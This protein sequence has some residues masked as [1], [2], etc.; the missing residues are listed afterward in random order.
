MSKLFDIPE[1]YNGQALF[2]SLE[3]LIAYA[4]EHEEELADIRIFS[5]RFDTDE[6]SE[7]VGGGK[8]CYTLSDMIHDFE[9]KNDSYFDDVK[10]Q[11]GSASICYEKY[12]EIVT[13]LR[14]DY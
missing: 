6:W 12:G 3:E 1:N 4:D 5:I 8:K 2:A 14:E 11:H 7:C 10:R 9:V 13:V